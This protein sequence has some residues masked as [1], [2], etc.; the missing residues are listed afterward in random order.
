MDRLACVNVAALPLQILLRIHPAWNRFPAVVVE[1]DRAQALVLHLNERARKA[2]IHPGQRYATAVAL[3]SELRAGTILQSQIED[4]VRMLTDRLRRYSPN[5]EPASDMPGVFWLDVQGLEAL[6]PSLCKWADAI[7]AEMQSAGMRATVAVGFTRFGVYALAMTCR[8]AVVCEDDAEERAKVQRIPLDRLN[9][10][11]DAQSRMFKL[12]IVTIGDFLRLPADGI[13]IRFGGETDA[14]YQLAAGHQWAPLLPAPAQALYERCVHFDAPENNAER[15][16]FVIKR[17]LD[18]MVMTLVPQARAIAD[19]TLQMHLD[20]HTPRTERIRSAAPTLDVAQL[21]ALIYLR[22]NTLHLSSGIVTLRVTAG[23]CPADFEQRPIFPERHRDADT[24]NQALA[25]VRAECGE[26]A[27]VRVRISS[28]HLPAAR[29]VWKPLAQI[30]SRSAPRIA[31]PR[32]LVRRIYTQP[33][34]L[35]RNV[36]EASA[37]EMLGPY[38]ISG[39]WW[40]GGA[41]REYYFVHMSSGDLWWVY[42]DGRRQRFFLQGQIE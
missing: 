38:V 22:L 6:Y 24:A 10:N 23:T 4:S 17:L 14:L 2:G 42:Y 28:A 29:F 27:V 3:A 19:V 31:V 33:R 37:P 35:P 7:R 20:D 1:D 15:L 34:P 16:L 32:P 30:A 41:H 40:A 9:F 26:Q 12:G 21:L 5:V 36:M 13:R 8:G 18:G 25:R 39:G 11:P